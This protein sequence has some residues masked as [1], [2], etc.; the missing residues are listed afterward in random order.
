MIINSPQNP[1]GGVLDAD[2]LT[3]AAALIERTNAWVLTDEV[4]SQMIYD[5]EFFKSIADPA[6]I[7]ER[8]IMLDELLEDL[9][10]DGL[11][12]GS[13]RRPRGR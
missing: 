11:A 13:R 6:G 3:A 4:Y 12:L 8:T 2:Q 9:R 1:T 10:D 7:A 5:G